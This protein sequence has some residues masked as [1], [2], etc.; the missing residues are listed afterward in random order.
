MRDIVIVG[1]G[2]FSR[3]VAWLIQRINGYEKQWNLL[4]YISDENALDVIGDDDYLCSYNKELSVV[5]GIG[6]SVLR[7]KLSKKYKIN[8]N[9]SFPNLIDPS[10]ILSSS[11][12]LGEGN[13]FCAGNI[14]TVD[15]E[16]G[17]FNLINLS[18]TIGHDTIIEDYVTV[19]PGVNISGNVKLRSGSCIG[20]GAKL[21]QGVCVGKNA[22]IG[23]GAVVINSI[24]ANCTAVG[25]PAKSIKFL[26]E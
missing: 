16:I 12:K 3:E 11:I 14:A 1:T 9:L 17:S 15:I 22:V 2:G 5:I 4:G 18:C 19:N 20:T 8:K 10:V 24:P 25:V 21:I 13:I 6:S 26:E 7:E 23:A